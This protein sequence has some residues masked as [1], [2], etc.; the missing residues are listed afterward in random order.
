[1]KS[2]VILL[3]NDDGPDSPLMVP[4]VEAVA[5]LPHCK[6]LRPVLPADEKSWISKSVTRFNPITSAPHHFGNTSGFLVTGTPA[7]CTSLGLGN[8]YSDKASLVFSGINMGINA[9]TAFLFSSGT[10][11]G[12]LEGA[13]YGVPAI[14]FSAEIPNEIFKLWHAR[15]LPPELEPEFRRI[16]EVSALVAAKLVSREFWKF[17][18]LLSVNLPWDVRPETEMRLTRLT[19]AYFVKL[20]HD[21]GENRYQHRM[22][23]LRIPASTASAEQL[24]GDFEAV[25]HGVISVTALSLDLTGT[26]PLSLVS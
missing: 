25:S 1:M 24:P 2:Q 26:A 21:I 20:F 11:G 13:L 4:F 16:A 6:E 15:Q 10:V 18:P 17:A 7:D 14:A 12:A 9:G 23:A 22:D 8:L 5:A 3:T 19:P